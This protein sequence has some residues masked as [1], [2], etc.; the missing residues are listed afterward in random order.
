[1]VRLHDSIDDWMERLYES[2]LLRYIKNP[3]FI[4][5]RAGSYSLIMTRPNDNQIKTPYFWY[6]S[7]ENRKEM[8]KS[9]QR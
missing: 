9:H 4:V 2:T 1:M 8:Y 5:L 3:R 7:D 6:L